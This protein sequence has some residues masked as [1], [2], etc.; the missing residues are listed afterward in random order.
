MAAAAAPPPPPPPLPTADSGP[1]TPEASAALRDLL[2]RYVGAVSDAN[3]SDLSLALFKR[4]W[5][6]AGLS[7][8]HRQRPAGQEPADYLQCLFAAA[9]VYISDTYEIY[10]RVGCVF[11]LYCLHGSQP[12]QPPMPIRLVRSLWDPLAQ[13]WQDVRRHSADCSAVLQLMHDQ[14]TLE[15][16]DVART[17]VGA[18]MADVAAMQAGM[19][20]SDVRAVGRPPLE[21]DSVQFVDTAALTAD[22]ALYREAKA[23]GGERA[24]AGAGSSET[25]RALAQLTYADRDWV[26]KF[27]VQWQERVA[28]VLTE[29]KAKLKEGRPPPPPPP[30]APGAAP[31]AAAGG[32]GAAAAAA[33]APMPT[34][35]AVASALVPPSGRYKR[36]APEMEEVQP[37]ARR[38]LPPEV[39]PAA[40]AAPE[41]PAEDHER[42]VRTTT[43]QLARRRARAHRWRAF[44]RAWLARSLSTCLPY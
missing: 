15:Y 39:A 31:A 11:L 5:R 21:L 17:G 26:S 33:A 23:K 13:L 41:E 18:S 19:Q 24:G 16:C 1:A 9:L 42:S 34:A 12:R 20:F 32:G 2:V 37:T 7:Q 35:M 10:M 6:A 22:M 36:A 3:E 25:A 28:A 27:G 8:L 14:G 38:R 43:L 44:C 30:P 4:Q 40:A 29:H